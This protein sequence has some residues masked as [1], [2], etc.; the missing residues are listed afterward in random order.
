MDIELDR[1]IQRNLFAFLP[2]LPDLLPDHEGW[3]AVLR[4]QKIAGLYAKLSEAIRSADGEFTDGRYSIQRVTDRPVELGM[5][6]G[7]IDQG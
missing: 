1:E 2:K 5:F 3:F 4:N 7:A 6:S